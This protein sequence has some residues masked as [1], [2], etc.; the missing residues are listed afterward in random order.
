MDKEYVKNEI[1]CMDEDVL[2]SII[3]CCKQLAIN[4]VPLYEWDC[5]AILDVF[6]DAIECLVLRFII[7]QIASTKCK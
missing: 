2:L 7:C 4:G 1:E 3:E 5:D 6:D